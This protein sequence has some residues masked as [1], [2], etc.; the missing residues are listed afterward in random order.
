MHRSLLDL[1]V[2]SISKMPLQVEAAQREVGDE[3]LEG[4]LRGSERRS[5]TITN[6]IPRLVLEA[7]ADQEQTGRSFDFKWR[8]RKSYDSPQVHREAQQWLAKRYGFESIEQMQDF[9][10]R[11]KEILDAGCG[12]G[13]SSSLWLSPSWKGEGRAEWVGVDISSAIDVARE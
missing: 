8:Q 3:I 10:A 9:F 6:G 2:D 4:R 12:S 1:L 7:D 11:R 5:Y 13:F